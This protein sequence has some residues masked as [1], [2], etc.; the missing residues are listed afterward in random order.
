MQRVQDQDNGINIKFGANKNR[1]GSYTPVSQHTET[2]KK[3]NFNG[4][5][6]EGESFTQFI[7]FQL[8]SSLFFSASFLVSDEKDQCTF[9]GRPCINYRVKIRG[10]LAA[11]Q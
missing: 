9:T 3:S 2:E 7:Y 10:N 11:D 4:T 5:N 6:K 8:F 1:K